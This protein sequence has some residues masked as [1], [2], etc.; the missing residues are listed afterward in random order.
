MLGRGEAGEAEVYDLVS[1]E[2][3][4]LPQ[5]PAQEAVAL[6]EPPDDVECGDGA[7]PKSWRSSHEVLQESGSSEAGAGEALC[8]WFVGCAPGVSKPPGE[9]PPEPPGETQ[10]YALLRALAESASAKS[11]VS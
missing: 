5:H 1:R 3:P 4:V 2:Q 8:R 9:P 6:G 7:T 10:K 11:F